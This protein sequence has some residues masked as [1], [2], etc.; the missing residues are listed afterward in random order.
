MNAALLDIRRVFSDVD[1][2]IPDSFDHSDRYYISLPDMFHGDFTSLA[3]GAAA[4]HEDPPPEARPGWTQEIGSAGY[5]FVCQAVLDFFEA[6]LKHDA[7]AAERLD[8]DIKDSRVA[9]GKYLPK[10]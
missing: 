5:Q 4:F 2:S 6:K 8:S 9:S 3:M 7:G 1:L 10:Q